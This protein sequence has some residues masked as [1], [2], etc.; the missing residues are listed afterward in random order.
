LTV[1]ARRDRCLTAGIA[2]LG[3]DSEFT[4]LVRRLPCLHG[5]STLTTFALAVEVVTAPLHWQ[6]HRRLVWR[7]PS[8][9]LENG[10]ARI[11]IG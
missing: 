11:A 2:E 4:P 6:Q 9:R 7:V 8:E 5:V 1:T 3:T 10:T